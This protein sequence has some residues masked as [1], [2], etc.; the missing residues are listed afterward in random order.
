MLAAAVGLGLVGVFFAVRRQRTDAVGLLHRS[1][2][3]PAC[4]R[5]GPE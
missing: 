3:I 4:K 2:S 1:K 5:L